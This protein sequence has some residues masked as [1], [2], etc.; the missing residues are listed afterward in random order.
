[1]IAYITAKQFFVYYFNTY[2]KLPNNVKAVDVCFKIVH[3]GI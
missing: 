2:Y 3:V 1:M